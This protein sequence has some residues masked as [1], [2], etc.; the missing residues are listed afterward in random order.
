LVAARTSAGTE[1]GRLLQMIHHL[2][3]GMIGG[4]EGGE[5]RAADISRVRSGNDAVLN[6]DGP[7]NRDSRPAATRRTRIGHDDSALHDRNVQQLG[8]ARA[9]GDDVGRFFGSFGFDCFGQRSGGVTRKKHRELLREL[10]FELGE[11]IGASEPSGLEV[12]GAAQGRAQAAAFV[13]AGSDQI[14]CFDFHSHG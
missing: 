7:A 14:A 5:H 1:V 4:E 3:D 12:A 9:S 2:A 13:P 11:E 8:H 10:E 6:F